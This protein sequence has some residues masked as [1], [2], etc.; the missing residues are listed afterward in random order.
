MAQLLPENIILHCSATPDGR[1]FSWGAIRRYHIERNGWSDIGYHYGI[2][3]YEDGIVLLQ[4]RSPWVQ[5]AHCR[6]GGR[7]RDSLGVCVVGCF[8]EVPPSP[9]LYLVT[10][11]TLRYLSYTFG[12]PPER[13]YGHREFESQKTCPGLKWNLPELRADVGRGLHSHPEVG[14]YMPLEFL[15]G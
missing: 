13:I 2:E 11:M 14:Y 15:G 5:G 6:A 8:D 7:N 12:I 10:V 3:E 1:T 4:G 9:D